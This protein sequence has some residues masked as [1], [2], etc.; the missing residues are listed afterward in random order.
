[1]KHIY[2]LPQSSCH[3]FSGSLAFTT[4][5]VEANFLYICSKCSLRY[6]NSTTRVATVDMITVEVGVPAHYHL[7]SRGCLL[8]TKLHLA[9]Q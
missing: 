1:M 3:S 6:Q 9:A 2:V 8:I 7:G 5:Q 4:T